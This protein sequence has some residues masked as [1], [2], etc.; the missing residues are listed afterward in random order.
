MNRVDV[1]ELVMGT[2]REGTDT[3]GTPVEELVGGAT[4]SAIG[5]ER[6]LGSV[7]GT[8]TVSIRP[9]VFPVLV[10]T[11]SAIA[12]FSTVCGGGTRV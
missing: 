11:P 3:T 2:M 6:V 9:P 1:V 8:L 10:M 4:C 12:W 7:C 5:T